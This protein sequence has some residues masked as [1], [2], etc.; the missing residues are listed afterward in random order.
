[1][2]LTCP[3][4]ASRFNLPASTLAPEGRR[5]KCSNCGDMWFQLPDPDELLA[6][7]ESAAEDG[8]VPIEDI[9]ESVKPISEGSSVPA[10][11]EKSD[12]KP[13]KERGPVTKQAI[14]VAAI[15]FLLL[16]TPL[17][18]FKNSMIAAWPESLAFY[19]AIGMVDASQSSAL[20]FDRLQADTQEGKIVITGQV[21]NL[22]PNDKILPAIEVSVRDEDEN[23]LI[24][25]TVKPPQ[26]LL[27]GEESLPFRASHAYEDMA[28]AKDIR[29]RF[30]LR[31]QAPKTAS[32][33]A[34]NT[35]SPH[36]DDSSHPPADGGSPKSPAHDA[37]HPHQESQSG[38]HPAEH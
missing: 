12:G 1:M 30:V 23:T 14:A 27:K 33:S 10:R 4:C 5:V 32:T 37:A 8:H 26:N 21:I 15:V 22:T 24:P 11:A 36:A 9:P 7:I 2:I 25:W 16:V 18:I 31:S 13:K 28:Q 29:V 34:D 38:N 20:V 3:K 17:F 19:S 35:Q 6:E